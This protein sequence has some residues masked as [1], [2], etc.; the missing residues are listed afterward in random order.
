M[1][2]WDDFVLLRSN[3]VML[4]RLI[5]TMAATNAPFLCPDS[6]SVAA[7]EARVRPMLPAAAQQLV[8]NGIVRLMRRGRRRLLCATDMKQLLESATT[9]QDKHEL[10]VAFTLLTRRLMAIENGHCDECLYPKQVCQCHIA[11]LHIKH[12]IQLF[13]HVGE[14]GRQN[15]SGRL[16]KALF[17]AKIVVQGIR[18]EVEE[19]MQYVHENSDSCVVLF[20]TFD[21]LTIAEYQTARERSLGADVANAKPLTLFLPDGTSNQAKNL[22][23]NLPAFLPR[24][25]IDG[26]AFNSWLDP[27]R[28][29]TEEHR[30]CTAQAAAMVLAE[31]GEHDAVPRMKEAV[32]RFILQ[33]ELHRVRASKR[34]RVLT[35]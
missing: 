35:D 33:T 11:P 31:L 2:A 19:M 4:R 10:V 1:H 25:R 17:G 24:I 15:N 6:A 13:Q 8:D 32:E 14:F 27:L 26:A 29:Q 21:S 3:T 18:T 16:L 34:G 30:V 23:R 20:P 22:E 9:P 28:R 7:L 12:K 5:S